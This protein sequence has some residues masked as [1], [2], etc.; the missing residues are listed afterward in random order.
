MA[1]IASLGVNLTANTGP[2]QKGLQKAGGL[3]SGFG[4][5]I[6]KLGGIAS[7][8]GVGGLGAMVKGA[9]DAGDR[10]Q[11]LGK[12][13]GLST[14]F[15]SEMRRAAD[16]SGTSL[17]TVAGSIKKMQRAAVEAQDGTATYADAFDK[18]GLN[19]GEFLSL[20]PDQQF[21]AMADALSKI[22]DP[23]QRTAIS[24]DIMGRSGSELIPLMEGG[25]AAI[26]KVRDA[27]REAGESLTQNQVDKMADVNDALRN[28]QGPLNGLANTLATQL[29]PALSNF[30]NLATGALP[31]VIDI[32]KGLFGI[33]GKGLGGGIAVLGQLLGGG[34][35]SG[36]IAAGSA[37]LKDIGVSGA[38]VSE[39]ARSVFDELTQ[40][41]QLKVQEEQ[42][43]ALQEIKRELKKGR[44]AF[45]F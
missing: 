30:I 6:G 12:Q 36:A 29:S 33:V 5:T 43:Q 39:G 7:L 32:F 10:L 8:V 25:A 19:V 27:S 26:D 9:I 37:A 28:L 44:G 3:A 42:V 20:T 40:E 34:G 17:E 24:M 15:L 4:R 23:A 21:N 18:L 13:T 41:K 45:A 11:K 1:T 16:L 14:E 2:F 35:I 31:G 38:Q 22:E